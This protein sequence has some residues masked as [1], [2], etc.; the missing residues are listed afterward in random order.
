CCHNRSLPVRQPL[1]DTSR[2][3]M[4]R[5]WREY[6]ARHWPTIALAFLMMVIEGSTVGL[7][8]Y[9]LQP[10]F[11]LVFVKG[12][13]NAMWWV[14]IAILVLFVVRALTGV[15]QRVLLVKV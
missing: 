6:V 10:M 13:L 11:D 8:S 5:L 1:A 7:L 3:L 4:G 15:V 12:N 9:M 2:A 14:G